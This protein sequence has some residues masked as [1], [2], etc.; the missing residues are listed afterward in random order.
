MLRTSALASGRC[1]PSDQSWSRHAPYLQESLS[2]SPVASCWR[3]SPTVMATCT[4]FHKTIADN[5]SSIS[6]IW[7]EVMLQAYL[8]GTLPLQDANHITMPSTR[9]DGTANLDGIHCLCFTPCLIGTWTFDRADVTHRHSNLVFGPS[10]CCSFRALSQSGVGLL[11]GHRLWQSLFL[12]SL[13]GL[14]KETCLLC[15]S[16]MSQDLTACM[17]MIDI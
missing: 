12:S 17:L 2:S 3:C 15:L 16:F 10:K 9:S 5:H 11:A 8:N 13:T 7:P 4:S 1:P 14:Y 6:R